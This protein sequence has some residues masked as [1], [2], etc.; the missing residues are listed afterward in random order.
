METTLG[1]GVIVT[2]RVELAGPSFKV[3]SKYTSRTLSGKRA[4]RTHP[5]F[6]VPRP[7]DA[8]L[9]TW[10][11]DGTAKSEVLG[12]LRGPAEDWQIWL[13]DAWEVFLQDARKPQGRW[14]LSYQTADRRQCVITNT[15]DPA[16]IAFCYLH[17]SLPN[18]HI[19]LEQWST[20]KELTPTDGPSISN[21]YTIDVK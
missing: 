8:C 19:T 3:A 16:D 9:T 15:F 21:T 14:Q 4:I 12:G 18:Q 11:A 2:R 7:Q 20:A 1:D 10:T 13:R 5:V 17:L 6:T